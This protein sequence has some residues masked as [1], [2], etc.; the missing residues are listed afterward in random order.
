MAI[1]DKRRRSPVW[2][3]YLLVTVVVLLVPA[4]YF[5]T[6]LENLVQAYVFLIDRRHYY[7]GDMVSRISIALYPNEPVAQNMEWKSHFI[8]RLQNNSMKLPAFNTGC[9][10]ETDSSD[11]SSVEHSRTS[12]A[13]PSE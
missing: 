10:T 5:G 7:L 9:W 6:R 13:P 4:I 3:A 12:A 2:P 8:K 1:D 11:E